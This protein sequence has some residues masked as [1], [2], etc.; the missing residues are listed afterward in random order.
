MSTSRARQVANFDPALLA[1]DEVSGDKVS[2]GTIGAGVIGASVTG[3]AGLTGSTSLGT[4]TVGDISHADIVYPA[5]HVVQTTTRF[6]DS[7]LSSL[8]TQGGTGSFLNTVVTGT[9]TPKYDDSSIIIFC[10]FLVS[11]L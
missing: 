8:G 1:A 10:K 4:V 3:G 2:G 6:R 11:N 7:T 9:I 5:G